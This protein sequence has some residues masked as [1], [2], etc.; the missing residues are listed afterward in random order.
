[1]ETKRVVL[2]YGPTNRKMH[3]LRRT[4]MGQMRNQ[5]L[6][7]VNYIVSTYVSEMCFYDFYR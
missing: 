2:I 3:I 1:M 4:R 5:L 7:S 6:C